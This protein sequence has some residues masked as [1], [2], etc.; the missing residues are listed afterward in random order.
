MAAAAGESQ[1]VVRARELARMRLLASGLLV[2]M[3]AV[4]VVSALL[5][6]GRPWLSYVRAFA[7]AAMVGAFADWFAVVALF[8]HPFGIPIPHTAIVPRNR[9]RIGESLGAFICNNFLAPEVVFA[10]LDSLDVAGRAARWL[11]EPANAAFLA[12]RSAGLLP[13]VLEALEDEH[14]RRFVRGAARRGIEGVEAAPL[15]A[16][17]LSVL[18]AHG[19]HQAVFDR[20]VEMAE[21]FLIRHEEGIRAKVAARTYRWVPRWVDDKLGDKVLFGLMETLSELRDPTH[22][23]RGEFHRAAE[24]LIGRLASDPSL[25]AE[26]ER[27]KAEVLRSKVA[28]DYLDHL[29]GEVKVRLKT[30]LAE[31]EGVIRQGLE[32]AVL[33]LGNRLRD[34]PRMQAILNSWVRRAAERHIVPHRGEIANFIAGV[35][36]RWDPRTLVAKL[37]LQVGKDLQYIRINGTVVGGLVGLA[38]YVVSGWLRN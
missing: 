32:R 20:A 6:E 27:I 29:W 33:A 36:A 1:E 26:G 9:E 25:L 37:E 17:V 28:E 18:M 34:D 35:V 38:I 22:P 24:D 10:K 21:D 2:L 19:R 5:E 4:F 12:R 7:E 14:V 23:W 16:R 8:R 3:F 15:A 31:D 11:G 13:P 30:D